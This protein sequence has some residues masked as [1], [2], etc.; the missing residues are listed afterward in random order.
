M[1]EFLIDAMPEDTMNYFRRKSWSGSLE[2]NVVKARDKESN[3]IF[4][5]YYVSD[6]DVN[7][8]EEYG[9]F[10]TSQGNAYEET[11]GRL[12]EQDKRWFNYVMSKNVG[13]TN[14]EGESYKQALINAQATRMAERI[15]RRIK[16][17]EGFMGDSAYSVKRVK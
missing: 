10:Y 7:D 13:V 16:D 12:S 8:V 6:G 17:I 15:N 1:K 11:M 3:P 2:I 14:E 9:E 5:A 4:R